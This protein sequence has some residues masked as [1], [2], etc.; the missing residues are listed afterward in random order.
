VTREAIIREI[1]QALVRNRNLLGYMVSEA[2]GLMTHEEFEWVARDLIPTIQVDLG[3]EHLTEKIRVL[4][5]LVSD[6][7]LDA[8]LVS[9]VFCCEPQKAQSI[10]NG[11]KGVG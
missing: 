1:V 9:T 3:V 5:E 11:L 4:S 7:Y 2:Q 8:E 10:L 6:E